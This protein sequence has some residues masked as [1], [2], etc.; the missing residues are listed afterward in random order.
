M[1][2]A[3]T[4]LTVIATERLSPTLVRVRLGGPGFAA[5]EPNDFTD[6]YVKLGF[7]EGEDQVVRTYTIRAVDTESQEL[8]IDFVVHGD[9]GVAGPWAAGAQPGD[10]VVARGLGGAYRPDPSADWHLIAGDESAL[11]AVAAPLEALP[12]D[13]TG[14]AFVEVADA[15]S[16][17]PLKAPAGVPVTWVHRSSAA[18]SRPGAALVESV[19]A[20]EWLPGE[21]HVFIHGE[22][23]AVMHG[24][25]GYVRK[26]RG[27]PAA[28]ASISGY[29]RLG[30]TEEGFRTWKRELAEAEA[31]A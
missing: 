14:H 2:R 7:G 5:L 24:L 20:A 19:R 18:D 23:Q 10:T 26:E 15:A 3:E 6:M 28:R 31:V 29:W 9:E 12:E 21:P 30:R 27:I 1:A 16:Q 25:R 4:T 22:A 17:I 11:P 13:A 8:T